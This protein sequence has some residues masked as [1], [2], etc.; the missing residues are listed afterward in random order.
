MA[1]QPL[2]EKGVVR[3]QQV[4]HGTVFAEEIGEEELGLAQEGLPQ[5]FIEVGEDV[6]VGPCAGEIAEKEPLSGEVVD[7]SVGSGVCHHTAD[8]CLQDCRVVQF[9]LVGEDQQ[10]VVRDAAPK[11]K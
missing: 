8:L 4:Q 1:G 3:I 9:A 7:E 11:K 6:G 5:V 2:I 10:F